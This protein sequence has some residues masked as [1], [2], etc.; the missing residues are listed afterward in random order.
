MAFNP[1]ENHKDIKDDIQKERR[2]FLKKAAYTAP[3]LIV[4]GQ[5]TRP[6]TAE[7]NKFG[8]TPPPP[9]DTGGWS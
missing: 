2:S 6:T 3:A 9:T 8:S 7:A 1:K 4:L 5:L